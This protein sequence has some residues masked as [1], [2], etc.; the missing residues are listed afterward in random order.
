MPSVRNV[1]PDAD[2][3]LSNSVVNHCLGKLKG[4]NRTVDH[5]NIQS[6]SLVVYTQ[7]RVINQ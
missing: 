3:N 4:I 2:A 5:V 7:L 1:V 6:S